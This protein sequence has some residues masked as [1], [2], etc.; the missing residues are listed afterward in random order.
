MVRR[1][2][3]DASVVVKWYLIEE[4]REES[5]LLRDDYIEGKVEL[6]AP[7]IM[8]FEVLNAIRYS[9]RE[10]PVKTLE[11]IAESL[12]LYNI[13]LYHLIRDYA[14]NVSR[15]SLEYN[16]TIYDASYVALA[17][18]EKTLLYTADNKLINMLDG[19]ILKYI[20][21]ISKYPS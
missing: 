16:I 7:S 1:I 14:K 9:R 15:I 18:Q 3:V 20:R 12:S 21:H 4:W 19:E 11:D 8:P 5:I 2:V 10:I 17:I 13:K 6:I